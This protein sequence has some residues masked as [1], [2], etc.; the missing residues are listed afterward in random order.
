MRKEVEELEDCEDCGYNG[1]WSNTP[2]QLALFE[3]KL[4]PVLNGSAVGTENWIQAL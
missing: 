2:R 1:D 4:N 3:I